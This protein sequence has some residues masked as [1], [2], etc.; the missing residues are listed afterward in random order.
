MP[1]GQAILRQ[2]FPD[3]F[4]VAA[5]EQPPKV[6]LPL[7]RMTRRLRR[8][9][10]E[11]GPGLGRLGLGLGLAAVPPGRAVRS[12][13]GWPWSSRSWRCLP[14]AGAAGIRGRS[15]GRS[16]SASTELHQS[17]AQS[18]Q[19]RVDQAGAS[20][21]DARRGPRALE[22]DRLVV[23]RRP[24]RVRVPSVWTPVGGASSAW[25]WAEGPPRARH[26]LGSIIGT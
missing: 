7:L 25:D 10:R 1:P 22:R 11:P 14:W 12:S 13:M 9:C 8:W 2:I 3:S 6:R 23:H 26:R 18:R 16:R 15:P 19:A 20:N 5:A 4:L 21:P 17:L 24:G